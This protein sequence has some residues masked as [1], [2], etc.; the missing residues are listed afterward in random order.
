MRSSSVLLPVEALRA[1]P[2]PRSDLMETLD[3]LGLAPSPENLL[4]LSFALARGDI[5][6]NLAVDA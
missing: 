6:P 2:D 5:D 4:A 3:G 1:D